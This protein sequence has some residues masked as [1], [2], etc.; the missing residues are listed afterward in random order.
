MNMATARDVM[1]HSVITV[2]PR[3]TLQEAIQLFAQHNISGAPV[4]DDRGQ[5]VGIV[6]ERDVVH[7]ASNS[8]IISLID[9]S[10]WVSPYT[11]V[12]EATRLTR[13][14]ELLSHTPVERIMTRRVHTVSPDATGSQVSGVMVRHRVNHVPVVDEEGTLVGIICRGD[15]IGFL[16]E[17]DGQA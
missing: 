3:T 9:S 2:G 7:F 15:L 1:Q 8:H 5:V 10:G 4:V 6:T 16:A 14:A 12:G 13:G 11:D 17:T